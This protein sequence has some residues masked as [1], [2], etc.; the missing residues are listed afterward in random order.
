MTPNTLLFDD[1]IPNEQSLMAV[2]DRIPSATSPRTILHYVDKLKDRKSHLI[3]AVVN[4]QQQIKADIYKNSIL[5]TRVRP[6]FSENMT[7][8]GL[9]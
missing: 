2:I 1:S 6:G 4:A 8:R 3:T 5:R 9:N 7:V